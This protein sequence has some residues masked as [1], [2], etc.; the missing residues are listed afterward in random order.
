MKTGSVH[1][2]MQEGSFAGR[3]LRQRFRRDILDRS[4]TVLITDSAED[5]RAMVAQQGVQR[6]RPV[7]DPE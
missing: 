5:T 6:L 4:G 7:R 1:G 2:N 3:E